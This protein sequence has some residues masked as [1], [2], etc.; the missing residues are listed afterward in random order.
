MAQEVVFTAT[1]T[2]SGFRDDGS[3]R[4][5]HAEVYRGYTL[6]DRDPWYAP[7]TEAED[8]HALLRGLFLT[9]FLAEAFF[10]DDDYRGAQQ[11]VVMS[12]SSK[13]AIGFAQRASERPEIDVVGVTSAGNTDFVKSLGY[14][15]QVVT[16]DGLDA[17]AVVPSVCIDMAGNGA[18]LAQVHQ[19]L[20]DQLAHSM[21]VGM[22]HH[23]AGPAEIT[24]GPAP[25]MFFAPTEVARRLETWGRSEYDERTS[26]ALTSFVT[27]SEKWMSIEPARGPEGAEAAWAKVFAGEI[28]P[29]SGCVV[30]LHAEP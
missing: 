22:S 20:G 5:A 1:P 30:S 13:T 11:V 26:D 28:A 23:D 16:Y 4:Q 27:G 6:T 3:H 19:R 14:Y 2:P 12:A 7:G 10:A 21:M 15:D 25:E 17:L 8:R 18:A 9:G 24:R 29:S